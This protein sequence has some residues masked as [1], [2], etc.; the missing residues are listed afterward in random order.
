MGE[1]VTDLLLTHFPKVLDVQFTARVEERLD[2]VEEGKEGWVVCV[3][4]FYEPFSEAL[5]AAAVQMR[6]VK[7]TPVPTGE[8]CPECGKPIVVKWGRKGKFLSCSGFPDCRFARPLTTGVKCPEA[9]CDGELVQRRSRRGIFYGCSRFPTCRHV[10]RQLPVTPV[11]APVEGSG[12]P[13]KEAS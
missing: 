12:V 9:H 5:K 1:V 4:E 2:G 7:Q 6:S 10:E 13:P 8:T 11:V 3:K